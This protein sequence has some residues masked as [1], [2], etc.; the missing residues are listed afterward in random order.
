MGCDI[1]MYREAFRDG[2]WVS[3][4]EW[5]SES[6]GSMYVDWDD[7]FTDRNYN[8]FGFLSK[9]VRYEHEVAFNPRGLPISMSKEVADDAEGW[10][11]GGHSHSYLSLR[12]LKDGRDYLKESKISISGMKDA[13]GHAA[14]MATMK[15]ESPNY[16]L[17][18]PYCQ[19][20]SD[21][22]AIQ[23]EIDVP[24][25]FIVGDAMDR[26]IGMFDGVEGEDH[27]VVFWFDN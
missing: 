1:H 11:V 24:A 26:I 27:R 2:A 15:T 17:L 6:D 25:I 4:D 9:G 12:D 19:W 21:K 7:R 5:K 16:E 3:V 8:L 22:T 14:L 23:F 13:E 18:Y 20:T 10:G